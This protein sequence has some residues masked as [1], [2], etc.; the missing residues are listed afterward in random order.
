MDVQF[1][2]LTC[3]DCGK[4]FRAPYYECTPPCRHTDF[5]ETGEMFAVCALCFRTTA[6][7]QTHLRR[8]RLESDIPEIV[9][10]ELCECPDVDNPLLVSLD[11]EGIKGKDINAWFEEREKQGLTLEGHVRT[12]QYLAMQ[13]KRRACV[14]RI[15]ELEDKAQAKTLGKDDGK[16]E[17]RFGDKILKMLPNRVREKHFPMGNVHAAIMFGPL[18]IE[19]GVAR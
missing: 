14:M 9:A 17:P 10:K 6:H 13:A 2:S 11:L 8:K 4:V 12:C 15:N 1:I 5:C 18:L 16:Y 19:N 7:E 3:N